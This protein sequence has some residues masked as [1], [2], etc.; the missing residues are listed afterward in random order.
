MV[1]GV[2]VGDVDQG[3]S[4]AAATRIRDMGGKAID[5]AADVVSRAGV[6]SMLNSAQ[7]VF[8]PL[9]GIINNTGIAQTK[10]FLDITEDDW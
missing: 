2:T 9:H 6:K 8:G 3:Q 5:V 1:G 4:E 10:P 7:N